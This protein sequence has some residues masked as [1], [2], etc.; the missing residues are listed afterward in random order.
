[1]NRPAAP[2]GAS[3]SPPNQLLQRPVPVGIAEP[4]HERRGSLL[5]G[6]AIKPVQTVS[7]PL[8]AVLLSAH[9]GQRGANRSLARQAAAP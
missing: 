6:E 8:H 1:M 3:A 7:E 4:E 5:E 9:A 2:S